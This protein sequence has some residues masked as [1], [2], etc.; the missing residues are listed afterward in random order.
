MYVARPGWAAVY[1]FGPMLAGL[2]MFAIGLAP[3][4]GTLSLV[5]AIVAAIHA[6]RLSKRIPEGFQRPAYSRWYGM[7]GIAAVIVTFIFLV[8]AFLFEPFHIP[9]GSMRPNLQVGQHIIVGKWGYGH[10]GSFGIT[11]FRA[12]ITEPL[13]RGDIVVFD[14]PPN[15]ALQ[16]IKRI[17]GLPGDVIVIRGNDLSINGQ[18]IKRERLTDAAPG[19]EQYQES[20][21]GNRYGILLDAKF[22]PAIRPIT[23]FPFIENCQYL[24]DELRCSVPAGHYFMLGDNRDNSQDSRYWGFVPQANIVGKVI[25][26]TP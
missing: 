21:D 7:L 20:L 17:I 16:Y 6:Y 19:L 11:P 4:M 22:S 8:R 24:K 14:Y 18:D 12:D 2:T 1:F 25:Y 10:Y 23:R 9:A 26:A 5:V 15:P 13:I 3:L